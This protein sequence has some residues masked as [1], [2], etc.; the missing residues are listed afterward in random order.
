MTISAVVF[1]SALGLS[2]MAD[3]AGVKRVA[4]PLP[5]LGGVETFIAWG[6]MLTFLV[7]LAD[8][9]S[10]GPLAVSFAWLFLLAVMFTYGQAAAQ[11]LLALMG[12]QGNG[13][14][15]PSPTGERYNAIRKFSGG[16][17]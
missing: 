3:E 12:E 11:N 8:I 17:I 6:V 7:V 9:E 1:I 5:K 13:E 4:N 10:T 15:A 16:S 2:Y 14:P